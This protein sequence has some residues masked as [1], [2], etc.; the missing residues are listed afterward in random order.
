[1]RTSENFQSNHDSK[2]GSS[3]NAFAKPARIETTS[4]FADCFAAICRVTKRAL[5]SVLVT[6]VGLL[7]GCQAASQADEN[8]KQVN[9]KYTNALI[10]ST[11][12][13]LLQ[14]AHNPVNW[15]PWG[16]EAFEKAKK[17]N[18][19][20]FVSVGYST[21]YWCHVMERESF[22]DEE[23][24]KLLNKHFIAI[25]VDREERPDIDE[26]LMLATQLMTGRGGWPNSV[27]LTTD[28]RPWLAGTYFPK[29]QFMSMLKQLSEVWVEQSDGVEKQANALSDAIRK[30]AAF[31]GESLA[32]NVQADPLK[33]VMAE[34]RQIYDAEHGGFGTSPK[35]PPHGVLR[36]LAL[37]AEEGKQEATEMLEATLDAMWCGGIHDHVGG[38]FHRYSTDKDWF[39]PHF[40]KMLYDNAQLMRAYTEAYA[41]TPQ[42]QYRAAVEDIFTWLQREMTH[43]GGAFFSAIDSESEGGE[44]G[45]YYTWSLEE[46]DSVLSSAQASR[47]A[48]V[49][50]FEKEGNFEEEA[51]G[52]KVGTNIPFLKREE[53]ELSLDESLATIRAQLNDARSKREYPH[54]D[55]KLLT[56]WNGLMISSLA[57]AGAVFED[58]KFIDAAVKAAD[59][60]GAN[61]RREGQL[62]RTWR[63]GKSSLPGYLNDYAFLC[64]AYVELFKATGNTD[65]LDKSVSLAVEMV[66]LF[67]DKELGGFY[68]TNKFHEELL[69]RTKNLS[70]GGNLP[71]GNGVAVQVLLDLA[72]MLEG[73]QELANRFSQAAEKALLSFSELIGTQ[74][75]TVEQLV[76]AN[77]QYLK[78]RQ[79]QSDSKDRHVSPVLSA[80]LVSDLETVRPGEEFGVRVEIAVTP[81][82]RLYA[83]ESSDIAK[84]TTIDW[85]AGETL[86]ISAAP[87]PVG[88]VKLDKVLEQEIATYSGA[89][90]FRAT[91]LLSEKAEDTCRL[92]CR[93]SYQACD[94]ARCYA[95]VEV[96]LEIKFPVEVRK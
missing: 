14:H 85:E 86:R 24:A 46:I 94:S 59:F 53:L 38:G 83:E 40:E 22:E 93:L 3:R 69:L 50:H 35:F 45:R 62:L 73:K 28:G 2:S 75:R 95:P 6:S 20:V 58:K 43:D 33:R 89:I 52:K 16:K 30:A 54:L 4:F 41:I 65:W 68:F 34:L 25:K 81:G 51:T 13:Y 18:K 21:C 96:D 23:V 90:V 67:E 71:V 82:Y 76:L 49:Y 70:G 27:F 91:A 5:N 44:E 12:P 92:R 42:H 72:G 47:F 84:P 39:L 9:H 26:Q 48:E 32:A 60:I 74:P 77:V 31:G 87:P 66:D 19:P 11:S 88:K 78:Q 10:N 29:P 7:L 57:R 1:M 79:T 55:D 36:L 61:L 63:E 64:E 8:S 56:S 37:E 80:R 15:M 17:E